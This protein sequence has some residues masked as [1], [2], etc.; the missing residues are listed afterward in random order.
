LEQVGKLLTIKTTNTGK[1][2]KQLL[3]VFATLAFGASVAQVPTNSW[4]TA[5][6]SNFPAGGLA[7]RLMDAVDANVIWLGSDDVFTSRNYCFYS[8][9]SNGGSSFTSGP[10]FPNSTAVGDTTDYVLA[11]IEGIDANTAWVCAFQRSAPYS[12]AN[13]GGGVIYRTTNG[14]A[15]WSNMTAAGMFSNV[16]N[17]FAD[18]VTFLTPS[19]GIA[20]GDPVGGAFEIWR[21]VNG[22]LSWSIVPSANIPAPQSNTEFAIV[23]KFAKQ[24][25]SNMWFGTNE[26]RMYYTTNSGV[27]WNVS[28]V[29]A[30]TATIQDVAFSSP[31]VG[32]A[33]FENGIDE[34]YR[35]I[36]GGQS[37][38][39]LS[40]GLGFF[41]LA[42]IPNT[43]AFVAVDWTNGNNIFYSLNNGGSWIN[44]GG[45][46]GIPYTSVDFGSTAV[47]WVGTFNSTVTPSN[48]GIFKYS[49]APVTS[50]ALPTSAFAIAPNLCLSNATA[51][52]NNSSS[53]SPAVSYTWSSAPTGAVFSSTSAATPTVTFSSAGVY[54]LTLLVANSTG[55]NVSNQV[56]TV[57]ACSLPSPAFTAPTG[58]ICN[59]APLVPNNTTTGGAPAPSYSWVATPSTGVTFSPSPI[60]ASPSIA[61]ATPG[62]YTLQMI[63]TNNSGSVAA[64]VQTVNI[65]SCLP[66]LAYTIPAVVDKCQST[67]RLKPVNSSTSQNGTNTYTWTIAPTTGVPTWSSSANNPAFNITNTVNPSQVYTLTLKANNNSGTSTLSQ[68][69]TVEYKNCTGINVNNLADELVVYPNPAHDQLNIIVPSEI[70][71]YSVKIVNVLGAVIVDEKITN[72]KESVNLNLTNKPKGV[73]FL[74]IETKGEKAT[75]KIIIE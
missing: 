3:S 72:S 38:T 56:V 35:T 23:N 5:Q 29:A 18:F 20:V 25:T 7:A 15:N 32:L 44:Y 60:A 57:Q 58:T 19:V 34:L 30:N 64:T 63:A 16:A 22:G 17:S 52:V 6:N 71:S 53:G 51:V 69:F 8:M 73:Y 27:T 26:G 10:I 2:K 48:G 67:D 21:T 43:N 62:I 45:G 46:S 4:T 13:Q 36:D 31:S 1:M 70:D 41:D 39:Q 65:V 42:A 14:G 59:K 12:T 24:G 54:T 75:K 40:S 49:G 9:S 50:T 74:T 28:N 47:G 11:N 55:T 33:I 61:M 37:W 66:A 68:T